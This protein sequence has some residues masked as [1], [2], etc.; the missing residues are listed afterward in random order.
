MTQAGVRVNIGLPRAVTCQVRIE[1]RVAPMEVPIEVQA[2]RQAIEEVTGRLPL[3]VWPV[4]VVEGKEKTKWTAGRKEAALTDY[5]FFLLV[6]AACN[7]ISM[8]E[9]SK[10]LVRYYEDYGLLFNET[11]IS[12]YEARSRLRSLFLFISGYRNTTKGKLAN[13]AYVADLETAIYAPYLLAKERYPWHKGN[14]LI[15]EVEY[16]EKA[17]KLFYYARPAQK[18][19][20]GFRLPNKG[21]EKHDD[22]L[23]ILDW[24]RKVIIENLDI[25]LSKNIEYTTRFDKRE[26]LTLTMR[27]V[28]LYTACIL[29]HIQNDL[30]LYQEDKYSLFGDKTEDMEVSWAKNERQRALDL[31]R[32]WS[33]RGK[34]SKQEYEELKSYSEKLLYQRLDRESL[35]EVLKLHLK[36]FRKKHKEKPSQKKSATS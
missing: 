20:T 16:I 28:D 13:P 10:Y 18:G 4:L 30:P 21:P 27:S 29:N 14:F 1:D 3:I 22:R 5:M 25:L 32:A 6:Q 33:N 12:V 9:F 36:E 11:E 17:D 23:V 8:K 31:F 35:R 24:C 2:R 7:T 15:Y 26:G 34:I 19:E